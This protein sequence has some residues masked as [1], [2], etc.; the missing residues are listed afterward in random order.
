MGFLR[1]ASKLSVSARA[2]LTTY[3]DTVS[4]SIR[5]DGI[6][7]S[8]A[9]HTTFELRVTPEDGQ[10]EFASRLSVWGNDANRLQPGRWTYVLYDP[11]HADRCE[12]DKDRLE[13]SS[14]RSTTV[15]IG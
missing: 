11:D 4:N 5:Q 15:S 9:M 12:L 1:S 3:H 7:Q 8:S 13:R 10:P 6:S 14:S 2:Q